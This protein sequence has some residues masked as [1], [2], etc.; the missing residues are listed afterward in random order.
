MPVWYKIS[1]AHHN[2]AILGPLIADS[3]NNLLNQHDLGDI[4]YWHDWKC[5]CK[6]I[7]FVASCL[8]G[9]WLGQL[10]GYAIPVSM[11]NFSKYPHRN[12]IIIYTSIN[13]D[14]KKSFL[15]IN[16]C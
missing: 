13:M 15:R 3:D 9:N 1:P 8:H 12:G 14:R 5:R 4:D 16:L 6:M 11:N 2:L 10:Q 7:I